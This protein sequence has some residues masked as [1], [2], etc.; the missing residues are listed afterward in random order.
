M[1]I[2]GRPWQHP[3]ASRPGRPE[4]FSQIGILDGETALLRDHVPG[5]LHRR[6]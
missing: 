2:G 6:P 5:R 4:Q 1:L 3:S